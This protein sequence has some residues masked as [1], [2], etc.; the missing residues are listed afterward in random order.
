M[1]VTFVYLNADAVD[2]K[3]YQLIVINNRDESY[4]RPT[5]YAAWEDG[6][7]AGKLFQ[8]QIIFFPPQ[9]RCFSSIWLFYEVPD[10]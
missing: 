4:D 7:L 8:K 6:I 10:A 9:F 1:C 3:D 2:E 5:S